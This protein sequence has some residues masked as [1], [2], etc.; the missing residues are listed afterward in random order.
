[1]Y[2]ESNIFKSHCELWLFQSSAC[3][4]TKAENSS[5]FSAEQECRWNSRNGT[6]KSLEITWPI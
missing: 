6:N 3:R 1:M 4:K 2:W 5:R